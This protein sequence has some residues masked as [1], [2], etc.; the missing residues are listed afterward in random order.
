MGFKLP[1]EADIRLFEAAAIP[2]AKVAL[3]TSELPRDY[4]D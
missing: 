3:E 1:N 4:R 2:P